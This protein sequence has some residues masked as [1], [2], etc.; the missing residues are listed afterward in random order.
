MANV[1]GE[2]A[3]NP[4]GFVV[5]TGCDGESFEADHGVAAPSVN[6]W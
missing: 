2:G 5:A 1:M 6:Q 4:C 3:E